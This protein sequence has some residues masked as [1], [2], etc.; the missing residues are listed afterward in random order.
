MQNGI[1]NNLGISNLLVG[2]YLL[3]LTLAWGSAYVCDPNLTL[4][5]AYVYDPNLTS[6]SAYVW[7]VSPILF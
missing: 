1:Q 7:E 2:D 4:G 5:S 6:G 3:T